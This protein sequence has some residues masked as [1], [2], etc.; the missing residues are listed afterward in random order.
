MAV[1][2]LGKLPPDVL[3]DLLARCPINDPRVIVG[4]RPGE[5]ASVLDIGTDTYLVAKSDPITFAT[6]EI[7]WYAVNVNANDIATTGGQPAWF[8][9]V[10]LLPEGKTDRALVDGI[11]DQINGACKALGV[12]LIGGHTEISYGIDRPII[13]GTMLGFVEKDRLVHTGSAQ[14]GDAVIVTKGIPIEATAI[15][16]GERAGELRQTLPAEFVDRCANYLHDP[17]ISV[18]KDARIAMQSGRVHAM[19]D[20]TEGGLVTALWELADASQ[21]QLVVDPY[22]A[23]LGDAAE[24]CK[25]FDL[26][27]LGAI[28]SGALLMAVHPDDSAA[29]IAALGEENIAAFEIGRVQDGGPVVIDS[30]TGKRLARPAR[31]EIARLFE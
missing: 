4:P 31:D 30:T 19:H 5:D 7:G 18:V 22:P 17:G 10:L 12:T 27:P 21:K 9:A 11:Y 28:A 2:P 23:V 26:D 20:P 6:E 25:L 8:M 14:P 1:F 15:I 24:L 3:A 29:V 16:A 13:A